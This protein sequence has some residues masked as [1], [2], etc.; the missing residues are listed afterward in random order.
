MMEK[1]LPKVG[2]EATAAINY[3]ATPVEDRDQSGG[4]NN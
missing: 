2:T 1:V 3:D 4:K